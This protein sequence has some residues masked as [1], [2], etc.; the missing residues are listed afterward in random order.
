MRTQKAKGMNSLNW[1]NSFN[2]ASQ[3]VLSCNICT[4]RYNNKKRIPKFLTC[5]HTFCTQ[6]L[7]RVAGKDTNI[8]CPTC[9]QVTILGENGVQGLQSN[10]YIINIKETMDKIGTPKVKG[11]AK[12][13]Q[14]PMSF[15]CERCSVSIC[16]DCTIIDHKEKD[17]HTI[18]DISAADSEQRTLL[19][20]QINK[21]M[22]TQ[23][24]LRGKL[25]QLL[26]E[27]QNLTTVKEESKK[28]ISKAFDKYHSVLDDRKAELMK[29]V[30][31]MCKSKRELIVKNISEVQGQV[32]SFDES[33]QIQDELVKRGKLIDVVTARAKLEAMVKS[34]T[35]FVDKLSIGPNYVKFD[36]TQGMEKIA[37]CVSKVGAFTVNQMLPSRVVIVEAGPMPACLP[38]EVTFK[39]LDFKDNILNG[40]SIDVL[41][42]DPENQQLES[43]I[44]NNPDQQ[45]HV[46]TFT[47]QMSGTHK[48]AVKFHGQVMKGCEVDI[49]VCSN[50]PVAVIG[51]EGE[52]QG[53]F[54]FPRA[55][56]VDSALNLYVADTG[57]KLIQ[58]FNSSGQFVSQFSIS[59]GNEDYS[60]CDL[61]LDHRHSLIACTETLLSPNML[62]TMGNSVAT[63]KTD[64]VL[65]HR[66]CN[67]IMKCALCVATN[68]Q[69]DIIVSDY[70]VHSLFMYDKNGSFLRRICSPS[71][72]FN[73]PAFICCDD[74]NNIIVS[75]TNND[76]VQ[77]F[78]NEGQ[79][80]YQFGKSGSQK[81]QL[82]Q[83][84]G[85]A[86]NSTEIVVVDSGNKRVQ[87]FSMDGK[88]QCMIESE[89]DPLNQPRGVALSN[90]GHIFVADRNN[91]CIKKY[92]YK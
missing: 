6:C 57:N 9:R 8:H 79:F 86:T 25:D 27:S 61:A 36:E 49:H 34:V 12:H 2:M 51:L 71:G 41:I 85:V 5:H 84:F 60:T 76:S 91:N 56:A 50:N 13:S 17:G 69:G 19:S 92:K 45:K 24:M 77:V 75:D 58:K 32:E 68:N 30:E 54:K 81:G 67:K 29:Q 59:G 11:C 40:Y 28:D 48:L 10:F 65:K 46:V 72:G 55:V 87:V 82:K 4:E 73:H 14:Q 80:K 74:K 88:F 1:K 38:A 21:S 16:R 63:Y 78:N 35:E 33:V 15:F 7:Q 31:E 3:N 89:D 43:K 22:E 53:K 20:S 47:P 18:K 66:F 37:K 90:D 52:G 39:L 44:I 42:T 26:S 64:G 83:P 70:L 62:P 23:K